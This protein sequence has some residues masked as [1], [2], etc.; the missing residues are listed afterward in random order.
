SSEQA[1]S[2]RAGSDSPSN[3]VVD[4]AAG[5]HALGQPEQTNA[6]STPEEPTLKR[7]RGDSGSLAG[8]NAQPR[9]TPSK[10][11]CPF[12][13]LPVETITAIAETC[14]QEM[15]ARL[16]LEALR[17]LHCSGRR[18]RFVVGTKASLWG[19]VHPAFPSEFLK[20][21]I[22]KS[23]HLSVAYEPKPQGVIQPWYGFVRFFRMIEEQM[24]R[25]ASL[26]VTI[27]KEHTES[28]WRILT[29]PFPHLRSLRVCITSPKPTPIFGSPYRLLRGRAGSL[30]HLEIV[31][32]PC[33]MD[34]APFTSIRSLLLS[35]GVKVKYKGVALLLSTAAQQLVELGIEN[36]RFDETPFL[37]DKVIILPRLRRIA[38]RERFE[39]HLLNLFISIHPPNCSVLQLDLS[40]HY[41]LDSTNLV[42]CVAPVVGTALKPR[43]RTI[44]QFR[45]HPALSTAS[46]ESEGN[47]N[48]DDEGFVI[49]IRSGRVGLGAAFRTFV[50]R[51]VASTSGDGEKMQM[52]LNVEDSLSGARD[53]GLTLANLR[54]YS[55]LHATQFKPLAVTKIVASVVDGH[56]RFL[57]KLLAP[58]GQKGFPALKSIVLNALTQNEVEVKPGSAARC[59]LGR[60]VDCLGDAFYGVN[61]DEDASGAPQDAL[62]VSLRGQFSGG[63]HL[64]HAAGITVQRY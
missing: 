57:L 30:Q 32:Y 63:G 4:K 13:K 44:L 18:L 23:D 9:S 1:S 8:T 49:R 53:G 52:E 14:Q 6:T 47:S 31:N 61:P 42:R 56:L 29:T 38:L 28:L 26:D 19:T 41:M 60:F 10:Q 16:Y 48:W 25:W 20:M 54:P 34:T 11:P 7:Q 2:S 27:T 58:D 62:T 39:D 64:D 51:V 55:E 5:G 17:V 43:D 45:L 15:P 50:K 36:V 21:S 22:A 37:L 46:W 35:E 12:D 3:G 40:T 59:S 24:D 33:E